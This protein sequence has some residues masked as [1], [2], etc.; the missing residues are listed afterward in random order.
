MAATKQGRGAGFNPPNRFERLR[1]EVDP[2]IEAEWGESEEHNA[3]PTELLVDSSRSILAENDSPD[4][5][6][7][8]SINPYRGCEHGCVYC[9]SG[10]TPILMSDGTTRPLEAV[11]IGDTIYGTA[12]AESDSRF[13]T[14]RVLAHWT[15]NKPAYRVGLQ[16]GSELVAS[17]D[18]RFL[19]Q[20]GWRFV[21]PCNGDGQR[22]HLS[23]DDTLIG[24]DTNRRVVA[25]EP[26]GVRPLFDIT[27]GTGDFIANGVVSHNCYARPSHEYLGFSAGLDFETKILVKPDAPEL[28][29]EAFRRPSWEAQVV[30][31]S[32]NTDCYQPVERRLGLTR[33]CLEVFLKYR[34]PVALITKSSLVTRDLDLLGQLAALDLVSVTISVTTLDPELARVMEPRAA[35]PEKRLEALEALARRGVPAGVLVAPVIPGLNDEEIPALLRESAARG[36]GSAGYVML[37]LPGAVEPL[38]VEWLERELP[39]R[40]A[41]VLHRIREV[42]GGK[43]SDSRFGVRMRGEGTMAESIRDLFAVMAKKHGL[44]ARRPALETRHFSRTAGKQLRLF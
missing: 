20:G 14:T 25:V 33:R 32:G 23:V 35:A 40:A 5:G 12:R 28:L 19:S 17:G 10:E 29:E 38:F 24:V 11:C 39:L 26:L 41:R 27:T 22:P 7:R 31:L 9:L 36:A 1:V 30:A 18:H 21:A 16:G 3:L 2:E 13:A 4:L 44:D 37:R 15:V 6:F 34:N 42:R 8:F 43:L